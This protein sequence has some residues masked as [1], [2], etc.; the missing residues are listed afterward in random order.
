M[1]SFHIAKGYDI[2]IM[3][4]GDDLRRFLWLVGRNC[5]LV[6]SLVCLRSLLRVSFLALGRREGTF[7][8]LLI[9]LEFTWT[10]NITY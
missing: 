7:N 9:C 3:G 10:L 5:L 2:V 8:F 6:L 1:S 4:L